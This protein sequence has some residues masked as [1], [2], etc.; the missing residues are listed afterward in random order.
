MGAYR[1]ANDIYQHRFTVGGRRFQKSADTTDVR[2][3]K[4]A[5]R[6]ESAPIQIWSRRA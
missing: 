6:H 1:P 3:A 2:E 5:E 4:K